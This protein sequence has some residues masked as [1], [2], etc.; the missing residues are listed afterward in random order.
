MRKLAALALAFALLLP[1]IVFAQ[2]TPGG[3][4][5]TETGDDAFGP[6]K[7]LS[8]ST[9]IGTYVIKPVLGLTGLIF[10]VL[11]IYAGFLW[12]TSQGDAS[13]VKKAKDI[14][15]ASV[16]GAVLMAMA[17]VLTNTVI[18]ALAPASGV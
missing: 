18:T 8:L 12:M 11:T 6:G 14:L 1:G 4:G 15:V 16:T 9:F 17:Y 13:R 7:D 10:L 2:L 3:S 5:L